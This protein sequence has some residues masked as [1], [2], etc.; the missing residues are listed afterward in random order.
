[1]ASLRMMGRNRG[2]MESISTKSTRQ[3]NREPPQAGIADTREIGRRNAGSIMGGAHGQALP[4]KR[5][6]DFRNEDALELLRVRVLVPEVSEER[7]SKTPRDC[8]SL[9]CWL[10][11]VLSFRKRLLRRPTNS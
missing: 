9:S 4:V 7:G 1:L 5:L 10:S 6:D 11:T 3:A 2:L 8:E